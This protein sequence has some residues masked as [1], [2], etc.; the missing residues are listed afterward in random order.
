M[1]GFFYPKSI[2]VVGVSDKPDNLG[3]NIVQNLIDIGFKGMVY[4]VGPSGGMIRETPIHKSPKEIGSN[5]D[6]AVIITPASVVPTAVRECGEAGIQRI[7]IESG[8]FTEF[9]GDRKTLENELVSLARQFD[10]RFIGPNCIGIVNTETSLATSFLPRKIPSATGNVS[11]ISQSGGIA[12]TYIEYFSHYDIYTNKVISIGNQLNVNQSD[13]LEYLVKED[14]GTEIICLYLEGIKEGRRLMEIAAQSEKPILAYKA[15]INAAGFASASSHTAVLSTDDKVVSAAFKQ[16]GILR[17][18]TTGEMV[19]LVKIFGLPLMRGRNLAIVSRS[20]GF[21]VIAADTAES[22]GFELPPFPAEAI[23]SVRE[24]VRGGVISL[25]NPLDLGDLFDLSVYASTVQRVLSNDNF[26]GML[27]AYTYDDEIGDDSRRLLRIVKDL[28]EKYGKPIALCL[29]I[30]EQEASYIKRNLGFPFFDTPEEGVQALRAS[31]QRHLFQERNRRTMPKVRTVVPKEAANII[32]RA[33]NENRNPSQAECFDI[34]KRYQIPAPEYRTVHTAQAAAEAAF[35]IGL[36]VALKIDVPSVVH[37]SDVGGVELNLTT[38]DDVGEAF[39]RMQQRLGNS[40]PG[41]EPFVAIVMGQAESNGQ[42]VILG[43][44]QDR[45]FG[46]TML[47][48]MGGIFA[49][50]M[51]DIS[52]RIAPINRNDAI[53]MIKEIKGY[54][55]LSGVRGRKPKD[56]DS[57][58]DILLK[59]SVLAQDFKEI[60]EI[61]MNPVMVHETGCLA[62]DVRFIL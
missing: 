22:S 7:I 53:E 18:Q 3:R 31:Y 40:L 60:K 10:I 19:N 41:H 59:L 33:T 21:A 44:K 16:A 17:V 4:A 45:S 25:R 34:L 39:T 32:R 48:G 38:P 9:A 42:E 50:L 23:S 43:V 61:D 49:E 20:G 56:V 26:H 54:G 47:F 14:N 37:K 12:D 57:L 24:H 11:I 27:L 35:Q 30:D 55:I 5:L 51:E 15:G 52:I 1:K 6:L 46:P 36:P 58:A 29:M 28:S 2:V 13:L 8:G 62:L